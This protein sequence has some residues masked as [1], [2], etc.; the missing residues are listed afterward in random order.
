MNRILSRQTG[1]QGAAD[2]GDLT[3]RNATWRNRN[4]RGFNAKAQRREGAKWEPR[5]ELRGHKN[6]Q[7]NAKED[8][9][10]EFA[11]VGMGS[12]IANH[13]SP[14][15][16][17]GV[18]GQEGDLTARNAEIAEMGWGFLTA[19]DAKHAKKATEESRRADAR[20]GEF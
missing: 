17:H 12:P 8:R 11:K 5:Q 3:A 13:Q 6:A 14:R 7:G 4:R 9:G 18:G 2:R 1:G 16:G 20:H 15:E 19:K 10:I